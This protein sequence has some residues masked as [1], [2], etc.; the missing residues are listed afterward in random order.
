MNMMNVFTLKLNPSTIAVNAVF[1]LAFWMNY[2][3]VLLLS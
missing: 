2:E 1:C 3:V